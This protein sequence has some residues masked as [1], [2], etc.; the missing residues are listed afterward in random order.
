[1]TD[2]ILREVKRIC[3]KYRTRDPFELLD[4]IWAV[5]RFTNCYERDGLKGYCTVI[6]RIKYAVINA[7]LPQEWQRIVAAH[8][9]AHLILHMDDIMHSPIKTL[10]DINLV[11]ST[12]QI[13][14]QAN[15]FAVDFLLEDDIVLES[16]H[17]EDMDFF[18]MARK[19]YIPPQLLAFKVYS[20]NHR[21]YAVEMP[22]NLDSQFLGK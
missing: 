12:G 21:G 7:N 20:M 2:F 17:D 13:E 8:E 15:L 18:S 5:T 10:R 14:F 9:G 11:D 16:L 4:C 3:T 6:H 19:L 22:I 1:M